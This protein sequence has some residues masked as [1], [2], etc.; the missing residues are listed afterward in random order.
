MLKLY[1]VF[2]SLID[3]FQGEG[4]ET[5]TRISYKKGRVFVVAGLPLTE[6]VINEISSK[7]EEKK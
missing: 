7:M 3:V 5:W 1:P 2:G 6:E 4:W